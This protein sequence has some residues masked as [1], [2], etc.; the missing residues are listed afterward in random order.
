MIY[1]KLY[2]AFVDTLTKDEEEVSDQDL[3]KM[4]GNVSLIDYGKEKEDEGSFIDSRGVVHIKNW[5]I[6]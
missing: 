6:Y 2:E 4:L 1:L 3:I 5:K